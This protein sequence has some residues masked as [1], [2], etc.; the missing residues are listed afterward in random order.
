MLHI[1]WNNERRYVTETWTEEKK[2]KKKRDTIDQ[3]PLL[4]SRHDTPQ[5]S[6]EGIL[7]NTHTTPISIS[8][9]EARV[10]VSRLQKSAAHA[11]PSREG[12]DEVVDREKQRREDK[13]IEGILDIY[14][15]FLPAR[16]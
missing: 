6:N 16:K 12:G 4:S 7:R 15:C 5:G 13:F 2:K 1:L 9:H 11:S 3:K 10:A 14:H 8:R